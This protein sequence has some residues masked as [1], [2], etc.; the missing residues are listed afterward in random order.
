MSH[1]YVK[2]KEE[3]FFKKHGIDDSFF[4][5]K[6]NKFKEK[7]DLSVWCNIG[8]TGHKIISNGKKTPGLTVF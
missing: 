7:W 2:E 3:F 6:K 1:D 8:N 4:Y 5:K